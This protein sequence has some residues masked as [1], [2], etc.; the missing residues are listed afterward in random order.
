MATHHVLTLTTTI[1]AAFDTAYA[2][3]SQPLNFPKWATGLSESLHHTARGWVAPTPE[4]EALV[5]FSPP[6]PYG[7]LDHHVRIDGKPEIYI[8]LRMVRNGD[9]VEASLTLFRSPGMD[10][11]AFAR[12]ADAVRRDL[13]ALRTLLEAEHDLPSSTLRQVE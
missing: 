2:F 8:P 13:Q 4:G 1:N 12:D 6:N 5:A 3:A 9:G 7:V 10:D 11:A